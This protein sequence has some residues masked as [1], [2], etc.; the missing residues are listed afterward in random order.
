MR[1]ST[2][3][4]LALGA[5]AASAASVKRQSS[6]QPVSVKG[7]A[8]FAGDERFYIRGVDYQPGGS[9][10]VADPI[11]D[12]EGC[13]RD[14][15]EFKKLGINAIRVYTVDNSASHDAC[16]NAL[17]DAGI[18]LILDVNTP[19]YSLNRAD[20]GPSYND[21]YLQNIFA[22]ID[23]FHAYDNTL[24]FF[25][26]N[27]VINDPETSAAA[28]YVKAVTRDIRQYIRSQGYRT[29]PVG[30]SAADVAEN[31]LE[32]AEYMNCGTDDE[33]S[34]FFAFNDYSWCDPSSFTVSGWDQKVKNFTGYG[35]PIFLSEYGC[36]INTREFNEVEAL[37][38]DK[39]T[40]VYSGGL[41]YEYSQE[42][43]NYGL[44]EIDGNSISELPDFG[45]LQKQFANTP[46]PS[47]DGGYNST[48][49]AS[50]C[51]SYSSPNWLVKDNS[52]PA[53]PDGAKKYMTAGA[54]PGPGLSGPGSQNAG[55][56]STGTATAGSGSPSQT[57]GSSSSGTSN[58]A[59]SVMDAKMSVAPLVCGAVVAMFTLFGATLL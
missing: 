48:G 4:T 40:P 3:A 42:P 47:G 38:S 33:R 30:Y 1:T 14:L 19:K 10:D 44:V 23:I 5:G 22:T 25:S 29:I 59:A 55:G 53:I 16:M 15:E 20:P 8:F 46:N 36:N 58:A 37:Y 24:A 18:Y 11:A 7:N 43:S 54:G 28:P 50:G 2:L 41:V 12:E 21:V 39:M 34:D 17:A 35:I 31:R 9:S 6:L 49:G 27:E 26:G 51:P 32:M 56:A 45:T 52:L 13:K 57:G